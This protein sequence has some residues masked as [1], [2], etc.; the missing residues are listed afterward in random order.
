MTEQERAIGRR[1]F[2]QAAATIP[3]AGALLWKVASMRPVRTGI[4]GP[5]GQGRVLMENANPSFLK[6]VAVCDIYPPNL[7]KGLEIAR[8]YH[9]P[10]AQG[11]GDYRQMLDR[12][13]IE[14][15]VIAAPLWM[16]GTMAIDALKAGKHVFVEKTMAYT[17]DECRQMIQTARA[18]KRNLQVGHQR[19]YS[20]L[21]HEA[22]SLIKAGTIGE[23]YHVRALWHRNG[24]WRRALTAGDK[25]DPTPWGYT[26]LEHLVNWRLYTK[27]SHGLMSELASHQIHAINW[28]FDQLPVSVMGSGGIYRYKDGREE[29]DHVYSI[30]EYPNNMTVLYSSIQSNAFDHYYEEFMGTKGTIILSG[31]TEAMLFMEGQKKSTEINVKVE[32][33]GPVMEASESRTR[34]AT[35]S[36]V[37]GSS[38]AGGLT[39]L[40]AYKLELEG[41][42]RTIH[43]GD[44]NWCDGMA[45]IRAAAPILKAREAIAEGKRIEFGKD[46][47]SV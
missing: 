35:G 31:E 47:C 20:P 46:L 42:A 12:K 24:D 19:A 4:I 15:I 11:Y 40:T 41:F 14:A 18:A 5:G 1:N 7:Q 23:I 37:A 25:F 21:Y 17:L 16:H 28:F 36:A 45:G 9:E 43:N 6:L 26:N 34:D 38:A 8:K 32:T 22:Y 27:Y 30:F 33:G 44:K 2:I 39:P 13:D 10:Q 3:V 29:N